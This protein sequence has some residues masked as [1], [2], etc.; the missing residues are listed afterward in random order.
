VIRTQL[1]LT[2]DQVQAVKRLARERGV[3]MAEIFRELVDEHLGTPR[4]DR[5][6]RAIQAVGKYHSGRHDVSR[7]HDRDLG[8]A[9]GR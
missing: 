6:L 7:Q 2:P 1:Q 4:D 9:F 3:S 5:L 8:E